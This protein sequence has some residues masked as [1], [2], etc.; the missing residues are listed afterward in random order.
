LSSSGSSSLTCWRT[1]L[2]FKKNRLRAEAGTS[3]ADGRVYKTGQSR[4]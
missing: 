3:E 4:G 2:N 1:C